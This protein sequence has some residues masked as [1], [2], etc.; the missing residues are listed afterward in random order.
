MMAE[1]APAVACEHCGASLTKA[2]ATGTPGVELV[3]S[4]V[5]I[6]GNRIEAHCPACDQD[7]RLPFQFVVVVPTR[8]R[9][10]P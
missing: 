6:R 4:T 5:A 1:P 10:A 9:R 3:K 7:S 2:R 8:R